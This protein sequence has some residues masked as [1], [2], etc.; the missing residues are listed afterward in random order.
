MSKKFFLNFVVVF[1]ISMIITLYIIFWINNV[2]AGFGDFF[3]VLARAIVEPS[4]AIS[5]WTLIILGIKTMIVVVAS[6]VIGT[7]FAYL[8]SKWSL[9]GVM[10]IIASFPEVFFLMMVWAVY[11]PIGI[12]EFKKGFLIVLVETIKTTGIFHKYFHESYIEYSQSHSYYLNNIRNIK[13][14]YIYTIKNTIGDSLG[15]MIFE[16]PLI[17]S[18]VAVLEASFSYVGISQSFFAAIGSS[19]ADVTIRRSIIILLILG[20][21]QLSIYYFISKRDVRKVAQ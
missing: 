18:S 12:S 21:I 8:L 10:N 17:F 5:W 4:E 13:R 15:N 3:K 1:L 9:K 20:I 16:V 19:Q 14:K 2:Y 7:I 11:L 6:I